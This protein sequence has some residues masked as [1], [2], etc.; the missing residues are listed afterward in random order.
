MP[1][2]IRSRHDAIR[3]LEAVAEPP[4]VVRA[5]RVDRLDGDDAVQLLVPP[6][7]DD[8]HPAAADGLFDTV[9]PDL[10][11]CLHQNRIGAF[12]RRGA[13]L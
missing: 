4:K 13:K 11:P 5:A 10:L 3:A 8:T 1:G 7:I 6:A 12:N 9:A 2:A